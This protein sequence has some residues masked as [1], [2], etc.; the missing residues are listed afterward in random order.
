MEM[1]SIDSKI[2]DLKKQLDEL[3]KQKQKLKT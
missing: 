3:I 2:K 1:T